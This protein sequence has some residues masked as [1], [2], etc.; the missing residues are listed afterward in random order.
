MKKK[1]TLETQSLR[2]LLAGGRCSQEGLCYK[3]LN[4]DSKIVFTVGRW[5]LF[6]DGR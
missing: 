5:S 6:G 2:P 4:W 3:N 1:A